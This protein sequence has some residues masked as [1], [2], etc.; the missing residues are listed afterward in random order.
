MTYTKQHD[1]NNLR[2]MPSIVKSN[3]GS[4]PGQKHCTVPLSP[5]Q[6]VLGVMG[7]FSVL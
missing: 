7:L 1:L 5:N 4:D 2:L 3:V 6:V